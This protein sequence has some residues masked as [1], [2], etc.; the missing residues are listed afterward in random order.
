MD[1]RLWGSSGFLVIWLRSW[2]IGNRIHEVSFDAGAGENRRRLE[3]MEDVIYLRKGSWLPSW[4][5]TNGP[6]PGEV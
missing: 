4:P 1:A 5:M 2:S 3:S 6:R